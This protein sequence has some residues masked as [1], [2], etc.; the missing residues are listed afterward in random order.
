MA[1]AVMPD[2]SP[3][4]LLVDNHELFRSGLRMIVESLPR[5]VNS[6]HEVASVDDCLQL[7][8]EHSIDIVFLDYSLIGFDGISTFSRLLLIDPHLKIV[9]LTD[10]D[11]VPASEVTLQAGV[12]GYMAKSVAVEE[13]GRAID[14]VMQG[15]MFMSQEIARQVGVESLSKTDET[16]PLD[17]LSRREL[18]V[19]LLLMGGHKPGAVGSMLFLSPKSVSTYK[20]RA[21]EKL[22]VDT[23]VELVELG[24]DNG[25]IG[26]Y[27]Q[28]SRAG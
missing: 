24:R 27:N 19:A 1:E 18:Q 6:V 5:T 21:F 25:I 26:N 2:Y 11:A 16:L 4:V 8:F 7:V 12:S 9:V 23:L 15:S 3:N 20:R 17:N 28:S 13:V 22:K 10:L 14:C